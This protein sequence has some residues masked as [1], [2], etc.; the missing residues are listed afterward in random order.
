L[1]FAIICRPTNLLLILP[2]SAYVMLYHRPQI[3]K[4]LLGV[5]LPGLFQLWYD[6][7]YFGDPFFQPQGHD[8]L[9]WSTSLIEGLGGIL[10]SPGRGLFV[11]SPILLCSFLG[12][13]LAWRCRGDP[14]LRAFSI[15]ILPTLLLYA[16][17]YN[18]WGGGPMDHVFWR[19]SRQS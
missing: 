9:F 10:L 16:K 1:A 5:L 13:A 2:L 18:W 6:Y 11:Y 3:G 8:I 19:I 15:G 4:F 17:W 7:A 14:L 12:M